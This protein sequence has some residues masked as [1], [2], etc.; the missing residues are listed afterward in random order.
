[1]GKKRESRGERDE[2]PRVRS[3]VT[4]PGEGPDSPAAEPGDA[5]SLEDRLAALRTE[6]D[7]LQDR[8]LRKLAELDNLRKRTRREILQAREQ[9]VAELAE[10]M[11]D[12]LDNLERALESVPAD[13]RDSSL[14]RGVEM[15][16]TQM[17]EGLGQ[18]GIQP[19]DPVGR[20]FDPHLHEALMEVDRDDLDPGTVVDELIRGYR[21]GDRL[22][23]ASKVRVSRRPAAGR[24]A[25]AEAE[26]PDAEFGDEDPAW[27]TS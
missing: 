10:R 2:E 21:M 5:A 23:R 3:A 17:L 22:I 15:V 19:I 27:P 7:E 8:H 12:V 4:D 18:L 6:K 25:D 13:Q 24:G 16:R 14:A 26:V 1:M 20:K 11:L 9:G